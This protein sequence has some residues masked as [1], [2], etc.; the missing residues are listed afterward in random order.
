M[1]DQFAKLIIE[2]TDFA[3]TKGIALALSAH[4]K[5]IGQMGYQR[6]TSVISAKWGDFNNFPWGKNLIDFHPDEED[7]VMKN[8]GIWTRL[9]EYQ[10]NYNWIIDR[11]HCTAQR[12][13][14][15]THNHVC[16]FKWLEERLLKLGFQLIFVR[17]SPGALA[18]TIEK[19]AIIRVNELVQKVIQEQDLLH[20]ITANS[21]LSKLVLD[22]S[23]M[24]NKESAEKIMDWLEESGLYHPPENIPIEKLVVPKF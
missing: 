15:Q 20:Q 22:V 23:D 21:I 1:Q 6:F 2:G 18:R 24:D 8:Y 10:S 5:V 9:I 17:Q 19:H 14:N 4:P 3:N 13:Q 7:E 12:Y 16:D 11:F